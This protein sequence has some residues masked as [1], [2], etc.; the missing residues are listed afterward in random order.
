MDIQGV[1]GVGGGDLFL[2]FLGDFLVLFGSDFVFPRPVHYT[3]N[4]ILI[5]Y[6]ILAPPNTD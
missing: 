6:T 1:V 4:F 3:P 2:D 5:F